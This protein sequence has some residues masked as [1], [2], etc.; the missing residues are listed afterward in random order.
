MAL[1]EAIL[2]CLTER[3]MTGYELAKAFDTSIGFFWRTGHQ[4]IYRELQ[5]LRSDG[6]VEAEEVI[7]TGKPNKQVYTLTPEGRARLRQW[8][9]LATERP[10]ARDEMLIKLY[11][12]D[13]VERPALREE[14]AMRLERHRARLALYERIL[15]RHFEGK[16]ATDRQ[17]GRLLGLKFGIMM[18]RGLIAWCEEAIG[19]L[20]QL[21]RT[22]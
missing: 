22:V 1:A 21:D 16:A 15:S 13:C 9:R 2:V 3:P 17:T 8:S 14:I 20:D 19:T 18:E 4:Q 7:Q 12:L 5:K 6:A 10:T 11:A